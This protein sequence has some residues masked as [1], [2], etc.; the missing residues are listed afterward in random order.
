MGKHQWLFAGIVSD[1]ITM[2]KA[3]LRLL[4]LE[5]LCLFSFREQKILHATKMP[6]E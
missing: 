4:K 3:P 5:F 2:E 6:Q 1:Y